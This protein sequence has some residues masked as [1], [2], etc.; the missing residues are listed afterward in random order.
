MD[1]PTDDEG[2]DE[3]IELK[4][5]ES[6]PMP[7]NNM[8]DTKTEAAIKIIKYLNIALGFAPIGQDLS[9]YDICIE[10]DCAACKADPND[11]PDNLDELDPSEQSGHYRLFAGDGIYLL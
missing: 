11:I 8:I 2:M 7:T 10:L 5:M 1:P 9:D 4:E 3:L 6:K